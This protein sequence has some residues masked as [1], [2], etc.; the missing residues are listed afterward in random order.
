MR[1]TAGYVVVLVLTSL[2]LAVCAGADVPLTPYTIDNAIDGPASVHAADIDGDGNLDVVAAAADADQIAWWRN[3]GGSPIGWTRYLIADAFGAAVSVRAADVDGDLDNDVVGAGWDRNQIAWWRNDGGNPPTWVKQS[4]AG[5]FIHAHEVCARDIDLDGDT[6]VAGVGA[7]NNTVAW[8]RNDGGSPIVW[9]QQTLSTSFG[10]GRSVWAADLDGDV[11]ID[12]VGA[13]LTD[14]EI[15]WW[16]NDGGSP[17]TWTELVISGTFGGA[18]MVRVADIDGDLDPDLV[19]AA[20]TGDEIAWW[21][22]DGGSPVVWTKFTVAAGFDAAVDVC[23]ADLDRDGDPDI[24]GTAQDSNHLAWWSNDGGDPI[25]WTMHT[26]D[27]AFAG[28]WPVNAADLDNDTYVDIIAGGQT[29]DEI[30]WWQNG[31]ALSGV[32]RGDAVA[33]PAGQARLEQNSPNPFGPVTSIRF[34]LAKPAHVRLVVYDISGRLVRTLADAR[35]E[36]GSH[37]VA[38]NGR[39]ERGREMPSGLYFYRL[40][41]DTAV[42]TRPMTLLR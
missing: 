16:R 40:V 2:G 28:V 42:E 38:W 9:T 17:I 6:D 27:N 3:D 26:I 4:I 31:L 34:D 18:H 33:V 13:A 35:A 30:R 12:I 8:W 41:A 14:N 39:D 24:L 21:R 37:S 23:P 29:A 20:Y 7:G 15:T 11:D 32:G 22:N 1:L 19:A 5:S 36:A 25:A 10:G